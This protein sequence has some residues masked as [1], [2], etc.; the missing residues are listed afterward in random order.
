MVTR[1]AFLAT[2]MPEPQ[3]AERRTAGP[4]FS[5]QMIEAVRAE[6]P[7]AGPAP[8]PNPMRNLQ[9]APAQATPDAGTQPAETGA[10]A[11]LAD[12]ENWFEDIEMCAA[13]GFSGAY[14]VRRALCASEQGAAEALRLVRKYAPEA[15]L[16]KDAY[17][18]P[19]APNRE[20]REIRLP[21]GERINAGAILDRYYQHGDGAHGLSDA[22][23]CSEIRMLM[24][25]GS[26]SG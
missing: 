25:E 5:Q 9:A 13:E 14:T 22:E 4:G 2:I 1:T 16:D 6:E 7:Q 19:W 11:P 17:T 12:Y 10:G 8:A 3:A 15:A 18:G 26:R 24:G 23:L 20:I 21:N